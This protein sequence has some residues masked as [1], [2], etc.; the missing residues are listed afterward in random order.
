MQA[1]WQAAQLETYCAGKNY[2]SIERESLTFVR[3]LAGCLAAL[4]AGKTLVLS[5]HKT[6]ISRAV[7]TVVRTERRRHCGCRC[8]GMAVRTFHF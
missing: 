4:V 3:R 8:L 2:L 6:P 1:H 7:H 5:S